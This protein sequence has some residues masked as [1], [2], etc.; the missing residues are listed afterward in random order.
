MQQRASHLPLA[1]RLRWPLLALATGLALA[2]GPA[3]AVQCIFRGADA[4]TRVVGNGAQFTPFPASI[5]RQDCEQLRVVMGTV[6]VLSLAPDG[7][8]LVQRTVQARE[9]LVSTPTSAERSTGATGLLRELGLAL[10]A[11]ETRR[12]GA[13]RG[14]DAL[15][16]PSAALPTG[17]LMEP[18]ADLRLPLPGPTDDQLQSFTLWLDGRML[19]RQAGPAAE[20]L[21]PA[22]ELKAGRRVQWQ[23]RYAGVETAGEVR[24]TSASDA[25]ALLRDIRSAD[26]T[27]L[28]LLQAEALAA[29][30]YRWDARE[31]LAPL[32]SAR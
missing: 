7:A 8:R 28:A 24:V 16:Y 12:S 31:R 4:D 30:G 29:A 19:P 10:R 15:D 13:S 2:W 6:T 21:L 5:V 32:V 18:T 9:R 17:L 27:E 26:P 25:A 22:A 3:S 11:D 23:L 14:S 20:L 1:G